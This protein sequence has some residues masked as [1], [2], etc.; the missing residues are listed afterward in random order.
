MDFT[1]S[2]CCYFKTLIFCGSLHLWFELLIQNSCQHLDSLHLLIDLWFASL[3]LG[4]NIIDHISLKIYDYQF[5][6]Q[7][8][9]LFLKLFSKLIPEM[10][11][12]RIQNEKCRVFSLGFKMKDP[13]QEFSTFDEH[14][15][16]AWLLKIKELKEMFL[17]KC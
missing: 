4:W 11:F 10:H 2:W 17:G 13:M 1:F 5:E 15:T 8:L 6:L 16:V 12:T 7:S 9:D 3:L 14:F